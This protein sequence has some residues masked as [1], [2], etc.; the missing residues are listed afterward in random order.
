MKRT[1]VLLGMKR[2]RRS[3]KAS[4]NDLEED[5]GWDYE[6]DLLRPEKVTIADDTNGYQLFGD[7]IFTCPQE[8]LL[9]GER[10]HDKG[11]MLFIWLFDRILWGAWFTTAKFVGQGGVRDNLRIQRYS[12]SSGN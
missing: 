9:E 7:K 5:E 11:N 12:Q 6:Y 8:D 1:P 10:N 4:S 3:I 2:K